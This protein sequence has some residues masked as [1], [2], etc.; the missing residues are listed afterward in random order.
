MAF[1]DR[2]VDEGKAGLNRTLKK[3]AKDALNKKFQVGD[4]E[5]A[6]YEEDARNAAGAAIIA[7]Q[8]E[9]NR[10]ATG[11][12]EGSVVRQGYSEAVEKAQKLAADAAVKA[13]GDSK[14]YQEGANASRKAAAIAQATS[15]AERQT[16][17]R[18]QFMANVF[19]GADLL[20]G[21]MGK[22]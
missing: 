8:S 12:G 9:G 14:K 4:R 18:Q 1:G 22:I 10:M 17:R 11:A 13:V 16:Q 19:K 21:L 2:R 5:L 6:G 20:G 3:N 15:E 7:T